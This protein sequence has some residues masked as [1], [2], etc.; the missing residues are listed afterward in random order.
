MMGETSQSNFTEYR[1][2]DNIYSYYNSITMFFV[3][4]LRISL[5][6]KCVHAIEILYSLF[7]TNNHARLFSILHV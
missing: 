4:I 1:F 6:E 5:A 7:D 3:M 2:I